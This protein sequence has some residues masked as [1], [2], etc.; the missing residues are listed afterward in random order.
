LFAA[1]E[2][3]PAAHAQATTTLSGTANSSAQTSVAGANNP[4]TLPANPPK[5]AEFGTIMTWVM[6]LFAW[7]LGV[8]MLTLDNVVYYTVVTMGNY[9]HQ[10][11]AVGTAWRVL[12]DVGN[13]VLIFGF[14]AIGISTILNTEKLGYGTKMLPML[15]VA[16]V[17]LNFSLFISEAIIDTGYLFATEIYTQINGGNPVAAPNYTATN[18]SNEAISNKIMS[19][20]GLQSIYG[21]ALHNPAALTGSSSWLIGFMGI[22]LF[23]VAAFVIFSLAFILIARF[24]ML[25]LLIIVAPIG[26]AGLAVPKL[27]GTAK[28]WWSTLFEQTITAPVLLLLLY[29]ALRVITAQSFLTGFGVGGG[30]GA[31]TAWNG[32]INNTNLTGFG[33]VLLSFIVAMGLLFAVVIVA[34]NMSGKAASWSTKMG[35]KLSFG[36]VAA[37]GRTTI[38]RGSQYLSRKVRTSGLGS[39]KTGRLLAGTFDRG[40]K[41]SF[42]VR[43]TGALKNLPGGGIDA[44]VAKKGGFRAREEASIKGHQDYIKSVDEAIGERG[45]RKVEEA[46]RARDAAETIAAPFKEKAEAANKQFKKHEKELA[47]LEN[48]EKT[49]VRFSIKNSPEQQ[50]QL[51]V[52]RQN[53]KQS[54]EDLR[55]ATVSLQK[56]AE[57]LEAAVTA[58]NKVNK[59]ISGEKKEARLAYANNIKGIPAWIVS[60]PGGGIAAG[61]IVKDA[62]K[63]EDKLDAIKKLL[64]EAEPDATNKPAKEEKSKDGSG[65]SERGGEEKQKSGEAH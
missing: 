40:A 24:I 64:K 18:V 14:L 47:D 26:F 36:L 55:I 56:P 42:D 2:Y 38:G 19:Q 58:E 28:L 51:D 62:L 49:R 22:I 9:V 32:F 54:A 27:S 46:Q 23:M 63:K 53:L 30:S 5:N 13:I 31:E 41:A 33:S 60:G 45:Q 3:A 61:K 59:D 57:N 35:G 12:R 29:I 17:F 34:K 39:T 37:G 7:L 65:K 11:S 25:I 15:L 52:A 10:L 1:G 4:I 50:S 6:T 21:D 8:A 20:L 48:A 16:A 44:G 43:G